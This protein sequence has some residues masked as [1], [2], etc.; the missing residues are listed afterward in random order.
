M[1]VENTNL[2]G[3]N[4]TMKAGGIAKLLKVNER[5]NR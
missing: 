1:K 5:A 4:D 2:D 3:I